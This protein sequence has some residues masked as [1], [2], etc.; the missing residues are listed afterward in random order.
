VGFDLLGLESIAAV[1]PPTNKAS[2]R[3][4]E[5][6]GFHCE[7][8]GRFYDQELELHLLSRHTFAGGRDTLV[9]DDGRT[10][11]ATLRDAR[12]AGEATNGRPA[13]IGPV[14]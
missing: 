8:M 9:V 1:I 5:K 13:A 2:L 11:H 7:R 4:A 14:T 12:P 10:G 3:V 6:L